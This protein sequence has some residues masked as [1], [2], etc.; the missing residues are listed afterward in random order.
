[1]EKNR[2]VKDS[3]EGRGHPTCVQMMIIEG[4]PGLLAA[5]THTLFKELTVLYQR[6]MGQG[7]RSYVALSAYCQTFV[8]PDMV[9]SDVV[10]GTKHNPTQVVTDLCSNTRS[11]LPGSSTLGE[12]F[13]FC[14]SVPALQEALYT[15][16]QFLVMT[17]TS[18]PL[19]TLLKIL[20]PVVWRSHNFR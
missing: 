5:C 13:S 12:S 10:L 15:L 14:V 2:L 7:K 18:T 17:R 8:L 19:L 6:R 9:R 16:A 1:M 20:L 4:Y 11:E 3:P